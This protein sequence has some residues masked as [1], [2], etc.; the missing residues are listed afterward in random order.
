MMRRKNEILIGN[1]LNLKKIL[2]K[3]KRV[4]HTEFKTL[5]GT[6]TQW[7]SGY[8]P[9]GASRVGLLELESNYPNLYP[10]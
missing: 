6:V 10:I 5:P 9:F 7:P 2:N 1:T 4:H 8:L 3:T